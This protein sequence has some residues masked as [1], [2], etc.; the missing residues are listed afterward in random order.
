M[1][2]VC[3]A[4]RW[5]G[6]IAPASWLRLMFLR[7][8]QESPF[9]LWYQALHPYCCHAKQF[10]IWGHLQI[11]Q[12]QKNCIEEPIQFHP[13]FLQ[14]LICD[15]RM[16]Q[17]NCR[18]PYLRCRKIWHQRTQCHRHSPA[19]TGTALLRTRKQKHGTW[20]WWFPKKSVSRL[21]MV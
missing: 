14:N 13:H 20:K 16:G 2:F 1:A 6:S 4:L 21:P 12:N 7:I 11:S 9:R 15:M 8:E 17:Q 10:N 5:L 18:P 3:P 19:S